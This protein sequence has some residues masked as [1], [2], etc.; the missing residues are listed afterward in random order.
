M[1]E[2]TTKTKAELFRMLAEAVRNT[3][4]QP[5]E[6]DPIFDVQAEPRRKTPPRK[7]RPS[8]KR[9]AK[10]KRVRRPPGRTKQRQ[11]HSR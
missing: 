1:N 6:A 9:I 8:S 4:P 3:Q 5:I 11:R 2:K 7:G 10:N